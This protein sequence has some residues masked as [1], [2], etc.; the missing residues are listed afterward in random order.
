MPQLLVGAAL[1]AAERDQK[2]RSRLYGATAMSFAVLAVIGFILAYVAAMRTGHWYYDALNL[3]DLPDIQE[4]WNRLRGVWNLGVLI[5]AVTALL[6]VLVICHQ[7]VTGATGNS[8]SWWRKWHRRVAYPGA[9]VGFFM[10]VEAVVLLFQM[11]FSVR[12]ASILLNAFMVL[13]NLVCG[14]VQARR[15]DIASHKMLMTF[16]VASTSLPSLLR[17]WGY[18]VLAV[19]DCS[20]VSVHGHMPAALTVLTLVVV[21][22]PV[23]VRAGDTQKKAVLMNMMAISLAMMLEVSNIAK[24]VKTGTN[25]QRYHE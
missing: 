21:M 10:I 5:H 14:I 8:T 6:W 15:K 20:M 24:S 4:A 23:V 22:V 11:P 18:V 12:Y 2:L 19:A 7:V 1:L 16:T 9:L 13:A 3:A 17:V 25:C